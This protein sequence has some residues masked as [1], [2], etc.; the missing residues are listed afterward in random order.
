MTGMTRLPDNTGPAPQTISG[1]LR[2]TGPQYSY[3]HT[4]GAAS[5]PS[6]VIYSMPPAGGA[7]MSMPPPTP[8]SVP[9]PGIPE[10]VPAVRPSW[11]AR[12]RKAIVAAAGLILTAVAAIVPPD[13]RV[14][15]IVAAVLVV[16]GTFGVWRAPNAPAP[17]PEHRKT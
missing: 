5:Y 13:S 15:V 9:N 17:A 10:R 7:P 4:A 16:G 11:W 6:T 1:P 3:V 14:G 12:N 8:P 2:L